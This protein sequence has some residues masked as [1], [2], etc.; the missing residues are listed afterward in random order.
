VAQSAHRAREKGEKGE[1]RENP[2]PGDEIS[3]CSPISGRVRGGGKKKRE[4]KKRG[5]RRKCLIELRQFGT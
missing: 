4:K 2:W 5:K 3:C 1:K